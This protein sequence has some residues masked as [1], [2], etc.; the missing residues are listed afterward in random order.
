MRITGSPGGTSLS[1]PALAIGGR[2]S[3]VTRIVTEAVEAPLR[4]IADNAGFAG[5]VILD[6]VKNGEDDWGFDAEAQRFGNLIELG[7]IDPVKV[8]RAALQ[9][10]ASV[11]AMVLTTESMITEIPEKASAAPPMPPMEY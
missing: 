3:L 11:A 1:S 6:G 7:I 10:A 2:L 9:N 4:L 5:S 8:T